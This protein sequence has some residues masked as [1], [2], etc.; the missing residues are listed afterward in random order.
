MRKMKKR[1]NK[2]I[3]SRHMTR[4]DASLKLD[5]IDVKIWLLIDCHWISYT[6]KPLYTIFHESYKKK[7]MPRSVFKTFSN[8][9]IKSHRW[10]VRDVS[11]VRH[12]DR[13]ITKHV[14]IHNQAFW[15]ILEHSIWKNDKEIAILSK[16][17][18]TRASRQFWRI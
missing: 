12:I 17:V 15:C 18:M 10:C 14:H 11:R 8:L 2:F 3:D 7:W 6:L 1:N 16:C 9:L 5:N 4:N 13:N